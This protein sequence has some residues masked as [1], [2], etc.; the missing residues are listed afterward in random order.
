MRG[1]PRFPL[2]A[3]PGN[4]RSQFGGEDPVDLARGVRSPVPPGFWLIF[5]LT[6]S[7]FSP[8]E[9]QRDALCSDDSEH[10][11]VRRNGAGPDSSRSCAI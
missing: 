6:G 8:S 4:L 11:V 5:P 1:N 10:L 7:F 9:E 3:H 2:Y